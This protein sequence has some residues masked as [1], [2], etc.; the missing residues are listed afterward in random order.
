MY[1]NIKIY[2]MNDN[3]Y[4]LA[5]LKQQQNYW[6]HVLVI[7]EVFLCFVLFILLHICI[8]NYIDRELAT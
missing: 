7:K 5:H 6:L 8:Y 3:K 2:D 4:S 1:R